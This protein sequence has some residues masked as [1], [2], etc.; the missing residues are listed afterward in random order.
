LVERLQA[1]GVIGRSV[2]SSMPAIKALQ[3]APDKA[4]EECAPAST[5]F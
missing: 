4:V 3:S 1:D 2:A 5:Q